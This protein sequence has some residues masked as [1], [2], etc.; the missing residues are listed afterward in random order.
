M[1]LQSFGLCYKI[2]KLN[3]IVSRGMKYYSKGKRLFLND[4]HFLI[5]RVGAS[6]GVGYRHL[7]FISGRKVTKDE[8][9]EAYRKHKLS[10]QLKELFND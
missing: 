3:G 4:K 6:G 10:L 7:Y 8:L 9:R 1:K 2:W 5:E